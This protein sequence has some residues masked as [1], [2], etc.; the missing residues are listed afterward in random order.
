MFTT[1]F[2]LVEVTLHAQNRV[3]SVSDVYT[4]LFSVHNVAESWI[5]QAVREAATICPAPCKFTFD[6]LTLKVASE[7]HVKWVTSVPI[8]V[9][10]DL[11]VLYSGPRYATDRRQTNV[12]RASSINARYPWGGGIIVAVVLLRIVSSYYSGIPEIS[13]SP[14]N[15]RDLTMCYPY[16]A[17]GSVRIN[18]LTKKSEW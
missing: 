11:S 8:L 7:S 6:L 4:F 15:F 14:V 10:L 5:E 12:R 2:R 1:L 16:D 13:L 18:I 17:N 9:F 3:L